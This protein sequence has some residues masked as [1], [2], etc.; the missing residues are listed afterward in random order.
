MTTRFFETHFSKPLSPPEFSPTELK[1]I[2]AISGKLGEPVD[3]DAGGEDQSPWS[4]TWS[5]R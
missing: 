4:F 1:L 5:R 2:Q 3:R